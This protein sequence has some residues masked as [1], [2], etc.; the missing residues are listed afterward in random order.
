MPAAPQTQLR[1]PLPLRVSVPAGRAGGLLRVAL[2]AS[3]AVTA[4][5]VG[6]FAALRS[7]AAHTPPPVPQVGAAAAPAIRHDSS[8]APAPESPTVATQNA[9]TAKPARPARVAGAADPFAV[10]LDVLQ[11][12]HA[13]YAR[14]DFSGALTLVAEHA[15]RFR[16][17]PLA[18]QREALR[19]R[20][21]VGSGR[22]DEA[23]RAASAFAVRFPRSVLLP[24]VE[25][26]AKAPE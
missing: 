2:A 20:S 19:V 12:A 5:A 22:R 26:D 16:K 18:E 4:G 11:R 14:R 23:Q 9:A 8:P 13:A 7:R 10:E 25:E 17:G 24:R 21:L 1:A 6:A 3:I 15:R